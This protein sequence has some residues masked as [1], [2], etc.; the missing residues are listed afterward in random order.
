MNYGQAPM[1]QNL[2]DTSHSTV[3]ESIV[4]TA[5][6]HLNSQEQTIQA[7]E[8]R[9]HKILNKATPPTNK[10]DGVAPAANDFAQ[11][12]NQEM[13]RLESNNRRLDAMLNHICE[14]V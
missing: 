1:A 3:L 8:D 6:N 13:Y 2:S 7:I 14:I 11:R 10:T 12:I 5:F 4:S 9:L